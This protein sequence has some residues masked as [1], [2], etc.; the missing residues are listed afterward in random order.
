[1][2]KVDE[3]NSCC[4]LFFTA[5]SLESSKWW[6]SL[7]KEK[8]KTGAFSRAKRLKRHNYQMQYVKLGWTL[9]LKK[10]FF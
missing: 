8:R 3:E 10:N 2:V 4:E 9:D 6:I 7:R 5:T 1:M